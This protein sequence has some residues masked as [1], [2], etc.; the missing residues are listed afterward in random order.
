MRKLPIGIQDFVGLRQDGYLYVDKTEAIYR[1]VTTGKVYFLSR[2]RRFGKS[3]LVSTLGALFEGR[4]ELFEGLWIAEEHEGVE[5]WPFE[6][7]PV[8]R[9]DMNANYFREGVANLK[10]HLRLQLAKSEALYGV[11]TP[12]EL[13]EPARF[14][15]LLSALH[16]K[17]KT[18]VAVLVDEYDK[19][20]L[21]TLDNPELHREMRSVL[22]AFYSVLKSAD[23]HLRFTF[24]TG[25]TK[26]SQVSIFSDLNHLNDISFDLPYAALCGITQAELEH[27]FEPEIATFGEM[28][29]TD[30]EA[31][32]ARRQRAINVLREWYDG[33]RFH[34]NALP[35]Y[36]PFSTFSALSKSTLRSYWFDTGTPTFLIRLIQ[37]QG[38]PLEDLEGVRLPSSAFSEID[39]ERLG[40]I[41]ILFQSGYVTLREYIPSVSSYLLG[42][43]NREVK[44]SFVELLAASGRTDA[45]IE[46]KDRVYLFEFKLDRASAEDALKQIDDKGYATPYLGAGKQ[47]TKVGVEFDSELRNI[48]RWVVG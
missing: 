27:N 47:V 39:P 13:S 37:Q 32:E 28:N 1:L 45:I 6:P 11:T 16:R 40:A 34:P 29:C 2:P 43:P 8:V 23:E 9:L 17:A 41:P 33:Y 31:P 44:Q 26:F 35:V 20:L 36:N 38:L 30:Q 12:V 46:T 24:L 21:E 7:G 14:S 25:V 3:L 10:E 15:L 19:P 18:R 48:E 22:K 42:Y 4:R 5:T